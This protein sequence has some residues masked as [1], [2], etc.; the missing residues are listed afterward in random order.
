MR[1]WKDMF[2][3]LEVRFTP[4]TAYSCFE[5]YR[6]SC[7]YTILWADEWTAVVLFQCAD[8]ERIQHITFDGDW[9]YILAG[10]DIVEYYKRV[11]PRGASRSQRR[12]RSRAG[13]KE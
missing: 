5:G 8:R 1:M 6:K 4:K 9:Y 3:K 10:R 11:T 2:G 12:A 13:K 7:P